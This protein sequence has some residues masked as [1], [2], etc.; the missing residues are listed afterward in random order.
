MLFIVHE[1]FATAQPL[2]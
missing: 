2:V 1:A